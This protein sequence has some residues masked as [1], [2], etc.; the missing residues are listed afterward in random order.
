MTMARVR[1]LD[2]RVYERIAAGEVIER[3]ANVVKELVENA[4]DAGATKVS[5]EIRGG[6]IELIRVRDDG[7]GMDPDDALLAIQRY[8]TS[9]LT[10]LEDLDGL[11]TL[12]FRGEALASIAAVSKM[13]LVTKTAEGRTG[14]RIS[15]QGGEVISVDEVGAVTG[16]AIEVRDLFYNVPARRKFMKGPGPEGARVTEAVQRLALTRMD[17]HFVHVVAGREVVNAPPTGTL[18]DRAVAVL[19]RDTA[20]Y[21][22]PVIDT[23]PEDNVDVSGL[24]GKPQLARP[25]RAQL[26]V[27]VNG[28][29][30]DAPTVS[31]AVRAAY[32]EILFRGRWP[33]AIVEVGV[34]PARVD[35]N[36]HPAKRE[37]LF[38][39]SELVTSAVTDAVR[40]T[41]MAADL[42]TEAA[43]RRTERPLDVGMPVAGPEVDVALVVPDVAEEGTASTQ[44]DLAGGVLEE[45]RLLSALDSGPIAGEEPDWDEM[46]HVPSWLVS[47]RPVGQIM[48]TY[49][50][51]EGEDAMYLIDQ[52]ALAERLTYES[53]KASAAHGRLKQQTLLEPILLHPTEQQLS[54]LEVRRDALESLGFVFFNTED[55]SILVQALPAMLGQKLTQDEVDVLLSDLLAGETSG[56]VAAKEEAIRSMACHLSI[57]AGRRLSPKQVVALLR[58]MAGSQDPLACVHGRPTAIRVTRA[59]LERMFKRTE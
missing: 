33:V 50:V 4:L 36:V 13:E 59:E 15:I 46:G 41:L 57:R 53:I 42:V 45:E 51:C 26:Y 7:S 24:V 21:M 27:S 37:V 2:R 56:T 19:G 44:V 16:T 39:D 14:T 22:F 9:K 38:R 48:D 12:G 11:G 58:G 17:V 8:T 10:T 35:V 25:N 52:H 5:T 28:R 18:Q 47:L 31:E 55:G 20:R 54:I 1:P 34:D 43:P 32:G 49:I 40:T 29:P 6:G 23:D 30:V 3:P